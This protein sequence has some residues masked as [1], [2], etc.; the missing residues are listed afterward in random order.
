MTNG[1]KCWWG[2]AGL[3][4]CL[5]GARG[6]RYWCRVCLV[7][8]GWRSPEQVAEER[9]AAKAEALREA[10]D[11]LDTTD[12]ATETALQG[13]DHAIDW[14]R[15]RAQRIEDA[16]GATDSAG[17]DSGATASPASREKGDSL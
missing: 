12:H 3:P 13:V 10:A 4:A 1:D 16:A 7:T 14:L 15:D 2:E 11:E 17:V 9:A 6:E 8:T 5:S